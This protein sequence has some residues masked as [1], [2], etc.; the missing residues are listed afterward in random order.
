MTSDDGLT[1]RRGISKA[2]TQAYIVQDITFL[3]IKTC[4][5][6]RVT[7]DGKSL[8]LGEN[9]AAKLGTLVKAWTDAQ[10]R[11]RIHRGKPLP[12]VLKHES[13]P[14]KRKRTEI[15]ILEPQSSSGQA[16]LEQAGPSAGS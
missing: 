4:K 3:D 15:V 8:Q 2:L 12:G 7:E 16:E 5:E 10:D 6:Q 11:V 14:R 13:R 9:D 1:A